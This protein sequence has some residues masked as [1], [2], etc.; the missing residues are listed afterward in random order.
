MSTSIPTPAGAALAGGSFDWSKWPGGHAGGADGGAP[1]PSGY[2]F[3]AM[4]E[5]VPATRANEDGAYAVQVDV[6]VADEKGK[7]KAFVDDAFFVWGSVGV[8]GENRAKAPRISAHVATAYALDKATARV[9]VVG[10]CS[11]SGVDEIALIKA[12]ALHVDVLTLGK[13]SKYGG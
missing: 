6:P 5:T 12:G 10:D 3:R 4:R 13:T 11:Q 9:T 8:S 1:F 2:G 7:P